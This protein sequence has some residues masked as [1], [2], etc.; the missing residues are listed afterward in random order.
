MT[1]RNQASMSLE[2][3]AALTKR[4]GS[5]FFTEAAIVEPAA[6]EDVREIDTP[7]GRSAFLRGIAAVI[8]A[9][10]K[11]QNQIAR[12]LLSSELAREGG[13]IPSQSEALLR[14]LVAKELVRRAHQAADALHHRPNIEVATEDADARRVINILRKASQDDLLS[15]YIG[16]DAFA[17]SLDQALARSSRPIS[18]EGA[19]GAEDIQIRPAPAHPSLPVPVIG[20]TE[21]VSGLNNQARSGETP[22]VVQPSQESNATGEHEE[23][24]ESAGRAP[25]TFAELWSQFTKDK[26]TKKE[27]GQQQQIQAK[28]TLRVFTEICKCKPP[29]EYT[30]ADA[31]DF[32][33]VLL[34]LPARYA[35][36]KRWCDLRKS[37]G[38]K[39]VAETATTENEAI[40]LAHR[41]GDRSKV[42]HEMLDPKT[43]DRHHSNLAEFW[44]WADRKGLLTLGHG[45]IFEGLFIELPKVSGRSP[46][47]KAKRDEWLDPNLDKLFT[48]PVL[49]GVRSRYWWKHRAEQI[50]RD[51]RYWGC[52]LGPHHG[53]RR[54]EFF[55]LNVM[56]VV[57]D[58][59]SGIW[60]FNLK[61]K[62]LRLKDIGSPRIVPI[63]KNVLELG[64]VEE[65][66]IGRRPSDMLFPEAI[67]Q[68]AA[69][70]HGARFGDWFGRFCD[71]LGVPDNNDF[72]AF[73]V[74]FINRLRRAGVA[75]HL[76]DELAGHEGHERRT[77]QEEYDRGIPLTMLKDIIDK[78]VLPIDIEALK[79]ASLRYGKVD[80]TA[81]WNDNA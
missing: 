44:R 76:V 38:L 33:L 12:T 63:H 74:T 14:E 68:D 45:Q 5:G 35:H 62:G 30:K 73:R 42:P 78:L 79:E 10:Q 23:A 26:A 28:S 39:V 46:V 21:M 66:V 69:G 75:P 18:P 15:D 20:D 16:S 41:K 54:E 57:Q 56:H 22:P 29:G 61:A 52:L 81:T 40:M 43:Y 64:F 2:D 7:Q 37:H 77:A 32:K 36:N 25:R 51:E 34:S 27:W 48:A 19:Y 9:D 53:M 17:A 3:V 8:N 50:L 70:Y 55:Q 6:S 31:D 47:A 4:I 24:T 49:T 80:L 1:V 60:Y 11:G 72:H 58:D 71:W 65:R 59:D 67:L 13:S